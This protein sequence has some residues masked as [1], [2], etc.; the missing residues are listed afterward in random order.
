MDEVEVKEEPTHDDVPIKE[1]ESVDG[2][3]SMD[4]TGSVKDEVPDDDKGTI[5]KREYTPIKAEDAEE[6]PQDNPNDDPG[7]DPSNG[8]HLNHN[9]DALFFVSAVDGEIYYLVDEIL[10]SRRK[11]GRFE[12]AIQWHGYPPA[13]DTWEPLRITIHLIPKRL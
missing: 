3:V 2:D 4:D 7:E 11:D 1:A 5:I 13:V 6:D 9:A 12:Y 10:D 8:L